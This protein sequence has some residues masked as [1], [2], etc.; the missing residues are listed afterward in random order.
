MR[1]ITTDYD[2]LKSETT[3]YDPLLAAE[4]IILDYL[5]QH[6]YIT[7]REAIHLTKLG[8]TRLKALFNQMIQDHKIKRI[9]KGRSSAYVAIS[10]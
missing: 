1:P 10:L 7:R 6:S 9:G 8:A 2:Q 3:D 5:S 4:K